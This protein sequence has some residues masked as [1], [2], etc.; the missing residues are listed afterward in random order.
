MEVKSGGGSVRWTK[1]MQD[2][3]D[4]QVVARKKPAASMQGGG[5]GLRWTPG[6]SNAVRLEDWGSQS[7]DEEIRMYSRINVSVQ[8]RIATTNIRLCGC[9]GPLRF[10]RFTPSLPLGELPTRGSS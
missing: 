2:G 1:T 5:G 8:R 7:M 10:R 6:A 4:T 9:I 3:T